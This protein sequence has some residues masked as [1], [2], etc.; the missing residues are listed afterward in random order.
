MAT[1]KVGIYR[2]Y[3][4][5]VPRNELGTPLPKS[6]WPRL[7]PFRWAVRWFG[8]IGNRFSKPPYLTKFRVRVIAGPH[9]G[10]LADIYAEHLSAIDG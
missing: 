8:S 10:R 6:E 4:G 2:K 3:H 1:E 9:R 7:R 5:T